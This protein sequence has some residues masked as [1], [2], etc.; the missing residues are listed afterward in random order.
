MV[1]GEQVTVNGGAPSQAALGRALNLSPAAVTKL[2]KQGMPVHSVEEAIAW[3]R[4]RLNIA[5]RKPDVQPPAP[6]APPPSVLD[7]SHDEARTRR[8]I[9][10]A[11]IAELKLAELRRA[12]VRADMVER[13]TQREHAMTRESL[14]QLPDRV[15][16]L[17]AADPS[18]AKMLQVLRTEIKALLSQLALEDG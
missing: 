9:A 15:V 8:E 4:A 11:N 16:P 3:R 7:E 13:E 18:P 1:N 5:H 12:L 10:E 14:L 17:L 6:S 2:K